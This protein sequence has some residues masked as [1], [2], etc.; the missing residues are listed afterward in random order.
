MLTCGF[1]SDRDVNYL[2]DSKDSPEDCTFVALLDSNQFYILL[3]S[4]L[5]KGARNISGASFMRH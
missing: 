2:S 1:V 3:C 5:A 4:Q